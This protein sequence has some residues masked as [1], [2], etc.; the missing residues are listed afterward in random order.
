MGIHQRPTTA[1]SIRNGIACSVVSAGD[2]LGDL[3]KFTL[4]QELLAMPQRDLT[5]EM[6]LERLREVFGKH[7]LDR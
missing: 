2:G 4:G 7:N 6:T 3:R 5:Q 1:Q